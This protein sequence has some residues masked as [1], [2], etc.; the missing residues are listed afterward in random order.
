MKNYFALPSP[1]M[2]SNALIDF[3]GLNNGID[4]YRQQSNYN[5]QV[6]RQ[7]EDQKYQ[8][9]RAA[10]SDAMAAQSHAWEQQD[11]TDNRQAAVIKNTAGVAQLIDQEQDPAKR[12]A[13]WGRFVGSDKRFGESFAKYGMDPSDHV[14]GPKFLLAQARGYQDPV[15]AEAARLGN[16]HTRAQIRSTNSLA[17]QRGQGG[18]GTPQ[19]R[20]I[21]AQ[22][23]GL[24]P[25]SDAGRSFILTGR[26]PREDQQSL[27]ATDK[28]AIFSAED[29]L[30]VLDST[31]KALELAKGLNEKAF[32]GYFAGIRGSIG[33]KLPDDVVP[34]FFASK[35]DANASNEFANI[36]SMESIKSMAE[37]LKGATTDNELNRF[38]AI[39][40]DPS[41]P[42]EIRGR[43]I[44]RMLE[45]AAAQKDVKSSRVRSLRDGTFYNPS[46]GGAPKQGQPPPQQA[47]P[48]AF[49]LG[50]GFSVRITP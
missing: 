32:S 9:G 37:T 13:M 29:E 35:D 12:Q 30:P 47:P 46:Q 10:K 45:L 24:D 44:E 23:Y 34:D 31:I 17:D 36:M 26:L 8:R 15:Q 49:D 21:A 22:Q 48:Q 6:E 27:T 5:G 2:P 42:P 40:G 38:V 19:A 7:Q 16:E 41:T 33:S 28:K 11:R 39:L 14:N 3:S 18:T 4:T 25:N 20:A 1:Q 43:T 50:D